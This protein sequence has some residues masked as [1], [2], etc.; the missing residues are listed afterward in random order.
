M[1]EKGKGIRGN[2]ERARDIYC[3]WRQRRHTWHRGKQRLVEVKGE[4]HAG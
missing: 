2:R 1:R 4:T 3:L